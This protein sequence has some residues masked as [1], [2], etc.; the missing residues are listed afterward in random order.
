M[1]NPPANPLGARFMNSTV[2]S[3]SSLSPRPL[4]LSTARCQ[5]WEGTAYN[6]WDGSGDGAPVFPGTGFMEGGQC[7]YMSLHDA[8]P[9]MPCA[10]TSLLSPHFVSRVLQIAQQLPCVKL[11]RFSLYIFPSCACGMPIPPLAPISS[12]KPMPVQR[13]LTFDCDAILPLPAG[14]SVVPNVGEGNSCGA[15]PTPRL[16]YSSNGCGNIGNSAPRRQPCS[17]S[18][19]FTE[20]CRPAPTATA[21]S[22]DDGLAPT[23]AVV[24]R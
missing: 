10:R 5:Q 3:P 12:T 20:Y 13:C 9:C 2:F 14:P 24:L 18:R 8:C 11:T 15:Y 23:A 17:T 4:H 1:A 21:S 6:T 16:P 7:M 22:T 19:L